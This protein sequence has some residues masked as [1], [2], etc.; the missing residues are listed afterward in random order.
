MTIIP[1]AKKLGKIHEQKVKSIM[2]RPRSPY[3][4]ADYKLSLP[5][6]LCAEVDLLLEDPLT[7]KP[8]YG[9]RSKL[10]EALLREWLSRQKGEDLPPVPTLTELK[11]A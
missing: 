8:K 4:R 10:I 1:L 9:A 11:G 3:L 5:A 6:P 7:K 2:P